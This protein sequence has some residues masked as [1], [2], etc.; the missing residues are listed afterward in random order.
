MPLVSGSVVIGVTLAD[1][2]AGGGGV[3]APAG[4]GTSAAASATRATAS[5]RTLRFIPARPTAENTFGDGDE[6]RS[7]RTRDPDRSRAALLAAA[8]RLFAERGYG[9]ASMADI[10][11]A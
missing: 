7:Q 3:W 11:A 1:L 6:R 4:A 2:D 5:V 8:E 10:G 9:G